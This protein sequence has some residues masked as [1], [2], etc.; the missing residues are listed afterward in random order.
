MPHWAKGAFR[1]G[2]PGAFGGGGWGPVATPTLL[3]AGKVEPR[4]AVGSVSTAEFFV[5]TAASVGFLIGIGGEGVRAPYVLA[6]MAGGVVAV[7]RVRGRED[8]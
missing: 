1:R 2:R 6:L 8:G 3:T 4:I 5:T 7:R